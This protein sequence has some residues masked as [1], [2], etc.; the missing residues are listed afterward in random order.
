MPLPVGSGTRRYRVP[1][2][3][4]G[5]VGGPHHEQTQV[6]T[7]SP[8]N[9]LGFTFTLSCARHDFGYRNYKAVGAFSA[10]KAR[11]DNAFYAD[12][13]RVCGT[14]PVLTQPACDALAWTYY[15][16]VHVFGSVVLTTTDLHRA[17]ALLPSHSSG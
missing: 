8:D 4:T 16:A 1:H 15:E 17:A 9:P 2:A 12:L 13:L 11:L 14:Y 7:A 3:V 6:R 10:N 5:R